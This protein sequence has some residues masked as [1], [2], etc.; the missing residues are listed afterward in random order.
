M[1]PSHFAIPVINLNKTV[2]F[3]EGQPT[4]GSNPIL[5][6]INY[7]YFLKKKDYTLKYTY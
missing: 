3:R 5:S 4:A 6:A 1:N 2:I 7:L